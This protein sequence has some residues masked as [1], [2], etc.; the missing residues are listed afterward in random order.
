[1]SLVASVFLLLFACYPAI[2]YPDVNSDVLWITY[3]SSSWY[4]YVNRNE[5]KTDQPQH[6]LNH[7]YARGY[8][9]VGHGAGYHNNDHYSWTLQRRR[10]AC[11]TK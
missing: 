8:D 11:S 3:S 1:M 4:T 5:V 6:V 2:D 7:Y 10:D 9:C